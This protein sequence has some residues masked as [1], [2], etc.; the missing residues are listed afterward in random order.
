ME[1]EDWLF[2][3]LGKYKSLIGRSMSTFQQAD[4]LVSPPAKIKLM[5]NRDR[6]RR[7]KIINSN[8]KLRHNLSII[9]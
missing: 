5:S 1:D 3:D 4:R 8:G 2:K 6:N 9:H 7:Q